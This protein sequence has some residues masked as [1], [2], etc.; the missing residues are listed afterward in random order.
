MLDKCFGVPANSAPAPDVVLV[1]ASQRLYHVVWLV[2]GTAGDLAL[3]FGVRLS[4]Y[5]PE[6]QQSV[7]CDR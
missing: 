6:A 4:R 2:A 3:S 5:S 7:L 1:D